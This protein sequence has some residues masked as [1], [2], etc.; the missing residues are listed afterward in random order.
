MAI[1]CL[2]FAT[3]AD[4]NYLDEGDDWGD[5]YEACNGSSQSPINLP[6]DG[7]K[8]NISKAEQNENMSWS[9]AYNKINKKDFEAKGDPAYTYQADASGSF[10]LMIDDMTTS[11]S[12]TQF[13]YH[14]PS[15]HRYDGDTRDLEIHFVHTNNAGDG[16]YGVLSVSFN[17]DGT[18]SPF[19][20][21]VL[22]G[23]G[24]GE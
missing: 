5:S 18:E 14:A 22:E 4:W 23:G 11:F 8:D 16:S 2:G 20:K 10:D 6:V 15:E 1:S 19:L 9:V 12:L 3:A 21:E 24:L 7:S 13:H 17:A